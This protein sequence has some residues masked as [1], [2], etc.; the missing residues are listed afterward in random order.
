M[1]QS[2]S[3]KGIHEGLLITPGEGN[4]E[5][6][7]SSLLEHLDSKPDFFFGAQAILQLGAHPLHA[8][9]LAALRSALADRGVGLHSILSEN[10]ATIEAAKSLG[11]GTTLPKREVK[12]SPFS[13]ELQG[14]EAIFLQQTLRSGNSIHFPGHVTV[15][16]DVNPGAEIVAGG[17]VIVWGH[18]RG[19]VHA[20]AQGAMDLSPMQL[21][22]GSLAATSPP[23]K[24]KTQPE[25]ASVRDGRLVA[26]PWSPKEKPK[27]ADGGIKGEDIQG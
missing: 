2:V 25:I 4:W 21:R 26:E 27:A 23:R 20:G 13:T 5:E 8:A 9:E 12:E 11:L 16:G 3:V 6:A 14:M 22:I 7:Y 10:P 1:P 15:L 24:G 18:L 17:S 19:T